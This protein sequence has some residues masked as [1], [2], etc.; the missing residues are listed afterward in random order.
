MTEAV[1]KAGWFAYF[2]DNYRWSAAI[3]MLCSTSCWGAA[4]MGEIDQVGRRLA[5]RVGDDAL[6]FREWVRMGD[7]MRR[8]GMAA[9]REKR[10]L[11]AAAFYKRACTYYQAG[12]RFRTP[13]DRRALGAY[14]KA[15]D[16]FMRFARLTDRPRV[17]RVEIPFEKGRSLPGLF[18]HAENTRRAKPPAVVFFDGLDVTK[19]LQ[20]MLGTEDLVRRGI[21][22]LLVDAPGNGEAIRF[23]KL[24]LRHDHEVAGAAAL[25]Y[26]ETRPDVNA[27]RVAVMGISLGGYYAPR[28]A[29]LERRFKACVGWG[30]EPDYHERWRKR[31]AAS[32][33]TA[34]SV[35]SHHIQWILNAKSLEEALGKL[36]PFRL[37][38]VV[39]KMRCPYLLV[40]GEDDQQVPLESARAL[41]RMVGSKDKTL[42]VFTGSEG[43]A[44]HCQ[45]DNAPLAAAFIHDWLKEKLGA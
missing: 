38:G 37:D 24:Y 1:R 7:R 3:S 14:R 5:A 31:I 10:G 27:K 16:C 11:T 35:P 25:D 41:F 12:E 21:S 45:M 43:G 18:V 6:W 40:H 44:Q 30:V 9:E 19:E 28:N 42:K 39:Q 32:F 20:Y 13:K 22:V 2:P 29:S 33:K 4:V 23:R 17:E 15:L 8:L 26:L 36:E 34:L